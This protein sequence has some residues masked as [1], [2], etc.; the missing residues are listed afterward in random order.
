MVMFL[1]IQSKWKQ[2]KEGDYIDHSILTEV[3]G[4]KFTINT[5][6]G[7]ATEMITIMVPFGTH[8]QTP[9]QQE[10]AKKRAEYLKQR[11]QKEYYKKLV[12]KE[13]GNFYWILADDVF[14]DLQPQT[15]AKLVMLC[16]YLYYDDM[17]RKSTKTTIK[18]S[19]LQQILNISK[20]AAYDFWR[21]VKDRYITERDGDLYISEQA[22]IFRGKLPK[23][24]EPE[25]IHYQK[26]YINSI[27]KLYRVTSIRKH[28][29]LGY[30]FKLLPYINLEYN[31]FCKDPFISEIDDIMPLS[32]VDLCGLIGYNVSQSARLLR[33]LQA[34]TFDINHRQEFLIS[35]VDNGGNTPQSKMVFVNPHILYNGSNFQKVE[36][37][38]AFCKA[39]SGNDSTLRKLSPKT[40]N[41]QISPQ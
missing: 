3:D 27:R 13:L 5:D 12:G 29:Q 16:T 21:E 26:A 18:K 22:N 6:T 40:Q 1:L 41:K 9:E 34:L 24:Q 19:D 35:Y 30:I 14:S 23:A 7:E 33:E 11:E 39:Y 25:V 17:F 8:W 38:G 20:K 4:K 10:K 28:K 37:L 15:V 32:V 36:V 2:Q 31:I